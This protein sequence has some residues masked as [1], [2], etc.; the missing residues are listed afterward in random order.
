MIFLGGGTNKAV[1][2]FRTVRLFRTFRVLRVTKLLRSLSYMKVITGVISRSINK[3]IL[4]FV[5]LLL[6][7]YI[8]A[9]L[10]MQIFGGN[11]DIEGNIGQDRIRQNFDSFLNAFIV[12]FQI[13][14]QENWN[15]MLFLMMRSTVTKPFTLAYLISW[16]FIGN[17]VFLNLFLAILLDEFT[18]E[19]AA[20][21]LEEMDEDG[22]E[23]DY[24]NNTSRGPTSDGRSYSNTMQKTKSMSLDSS[25]RRSLTS[26][27]EG[28]T[29]GEG[30]TSSAHVQKRRQ[31]EQIIECN[32]TFYIFAKDN[33]LRRSCMQLMHHPWFENSVLI[34]IAI[35]SIKLAIDTYITDTDSVP[36]DVSK[37][38]DIGI[39]VF[40]TIEM[41]TK[42]IAIGFFFD[43]GSYLRETWNILDFIIVV[44]SLLDMSVASINLGFIKILRLLRTLRPLRFVTHNPSMRLVVTALLESKTAIFNVLIVI[45]M[46]WY[47][48][49]G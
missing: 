27:T 28:E 36:Y 14:T 35:S 21:D 33:W 37:K 49:F 15:T 42:I 1:S 25:F 46:I 3:F 43:N 22:E 44:A 16:I 48:F 19:E 45:V 20:E 13:M 10:G 6:F 29:D 5:L 23:D 40:F 32:R 39:N 18:G 8:Y 34:M 26:M 17:Y 4:I 9:L 47:F 12:V 24:H 38:I 11:L 2:A 41:L 7:I 30:S 31:H